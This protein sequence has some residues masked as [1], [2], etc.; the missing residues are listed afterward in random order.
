MAGIGIPT[1]TEVTAM[2]EIVTADG[3]ATVG[4]G[5]VTDGIATEKGSSNLVD[6]WTN[7]NL[8]TTAISPLRRRATSPPPFLSDRLRK[9]GAT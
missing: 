4:V 6:N 9:T 3:I 1:T 5:I 7:L 8:P 2:R